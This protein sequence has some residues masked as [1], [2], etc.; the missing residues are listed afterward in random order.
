MRGVHVL[1]T[2]QI[3]E[4]K[5]KKFY[6]STYK[7]LYNI[8]YYSDIRIDFPFSF[9]TKY[10]TLVTCCKFIF[11]LFGISNIIKFAKFR[12]ENIERVLNYGHL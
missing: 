9:I 6:S 12:N 7:L 2:M 1:N 8:Q 4:L 11:C 10:A 5:K 3:M